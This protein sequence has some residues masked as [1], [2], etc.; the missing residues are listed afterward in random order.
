[1]P[2]RPTADIPQGLWRSKEDAIKGGRGP[3][4]KQARAIIAKM[5]EE[6]DVKGL[7]LVIEEG[8]ESWSFSPFN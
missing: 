1:M 5:Y 8:V 4:H 2:L 7:R 6:I 3:W